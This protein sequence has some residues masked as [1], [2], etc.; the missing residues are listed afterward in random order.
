[1][2]RSQF[3]ESVYRLKADEDYSFDCHPGVA[4]FT[5]CCRMLELALTPYDVLRLRRGTGL[6]SQQLHDQYIIE[7]RGERDMFPKYYL[8]MIDDGRASCAFVGADGCQVYPHRPGACRAYPLGRAAVR[9]KS[10]ELQ[11]HFVLLKESHCKGFA[12]TRPQTPLLYS[13]E[14]GLAEYN[15]YNDA[16][17]SLIQHDEIRQGRFMPSDEQLRLFALALYNLDQF[18]DDITRGALPGLD[19]GSEILE[20]DERLLLFAIE[21]LK[22]MFFSSP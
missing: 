20:N 6:T 14:Q 22:G 11:Q 17:A 15:L 4:C 8:T 9:T 2:I 5:E 13:K 3:P 7:E 18:R 16:L 10:G 19:C 1:M 12:E 21:W